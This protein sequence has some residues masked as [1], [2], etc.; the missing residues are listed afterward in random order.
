MDSIY[1]WTNLVR[2][3]PLLL[4]SKNLLL[5]Q[6]CMLYIANKSSNGEAT[7]LYELT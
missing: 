1:M 2:M 6:I 4:I 7:A 5:Q 3:F